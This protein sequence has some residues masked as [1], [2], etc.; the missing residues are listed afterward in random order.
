MRT[1]LTILL[2][3]C[4]YNKGTGFSLEH[5]QEIL[6]RNKRY[7]YTHPE[8]CV[9]DGVTDNICFYGSQNIPYQMALI[10]VSAGSGIIIDNMRQKVAVI[11]NSGKA[12]I[13]D[14]NSHSGVRCNMNPTTTKE[15][16]DVVKNFNISESFNKHQPNNFTYDEYGLSE[17]LAPNETKDN[18]DSFLL[19][20]IRTFG[21]EF[22]DY[23]NEIIGLAGGVASSIMKAFHDIMKHLSVVLAPIVVLAT[24]GFLVLKAGILG[25]RRI[26]KTLSRFAMKV[27]GGVGTLIAAGISF[28]LGIIMVGLNGLTSFFLVLYEISK[29]LALADVVKFLLVS[30]LI[31]YET[32]AGLGGMILHGITGV[33]TIVYH[34]IKIVSKGILNAIKS[35]VQSITNLVLRFFG[36]RATTKENYKENLQESAGLLLELL[37][38][39]TI[40]GEDSLGP[41][42]NFAEGMTNKKALIVFGIN[43]NE[44]IQILTD[45]SIENGFEMVSA[46]IKIF[47]PFKIPNFLSK[48]MADIFANSVSLL[49]KD[50]D[51]S[52]VQHILPGIVPPPEGVFSISSQDPSVLDL[53]TYQLIEKIPTLHAV[54]VSLEKYSKSYYNV[55]LIKQLE[56][57]PE[58][59]NM[60]NLGIRRIAAY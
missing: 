1:L 48:A 49:S 22:H 9:T 4:C 31:V 27:V 2:L 5:L 43:V 19:K 33:F 54:F 18:I 13:L 59:N 20:T 57:D 24:K 25:I 40:T 14:H 8:P 37:N 15:F 39:Q 17:L 52:Y 11:V 55:S 44:V 6:V 46:I 36:V 60:I 42:I 35:G 32:I 29:K 50:N 47:F 12:V 53:P 51:L 21:P 58:F 3:V 26:F 10:N 23:I 45:P 30:P 16:P 41:L 38:N 7:A 34:I 56:T 28:P